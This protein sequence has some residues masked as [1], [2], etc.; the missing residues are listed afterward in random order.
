MAVVVVVS[1]VVVVVVVVVVGVVVIVVVE[2]G[3]VVVIVVVV[4]GGGK[5][6]K[7]GV[8]VCFVFV[9]SSRISNPT[10]VLIWWAAVVG[11]TSV[12]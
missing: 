5:V 8:I 10:M 7:V 12:I 4:G 11:G 1:V 9:K 6:G 3:V 2:V